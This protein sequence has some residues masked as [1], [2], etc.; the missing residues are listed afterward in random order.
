MRRFINVLLI[1]LSTLLV[2]FAL[3]ESIGRIGDLKL[4]K[5][6]PEIFDKDSFHIHYAKN[7]LIMYIHV[8]A[9]MIFLLSGAYQLVPYFRKRNIQI[10]RLI[11]KVF[12]IISFIVSVSAIVLAIFYPYSDKIESFTNLIFGVYI[13]YATVKAFTTIRKKRV[14][15]HANWVRRVFFVS[16]SIA[17]IRL[18]MIAMMVISNNTVQ[19]VMGTSFFIGFLLHTII[20]EAWIAQNMKTNTNNSVFK[21]L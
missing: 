15:D 18:I 20:V 4:A 6:N 13:L 21:Q 14:L 5:D 2:L 9:G 19:E 7:A 10:H 17:T 8:I 16:L 11:G 12:L 1:T 3:G